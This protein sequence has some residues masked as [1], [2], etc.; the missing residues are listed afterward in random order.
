MK[1]GNSHDNILP[2]Q[3]RAFEKLS[4]MASV[5]FTVDRTQFPLNI[6]PNVCIVGPSGVGK[7]HL[8]RAVGKEIGIPTFY[9]NISTWQLLGS[10]LRGAV[11]TWPTVFDFL[12]SCS[13][14]RGAIIIVDE[15]DKVGGNTSW[16]TYLRS[17]LFDLLDWRIPRNLKDSDD[18]MISSNRIFLA[19]KTLREKT[20]IVG[21][22]AF[23]GFWENDSKSGIGFLQPQFTENRP[24]TRDLSKTLPTEL[25]NRFGSNIISLPPLARRDYLG[26]LDSFLGRMPEFCRERFEVASREGIDEAVRLNLGTRFFEETLLMTLMDELGDDSRC[27]PET[28]VPS[29]SPKS[30]SIGNS[31]SLGL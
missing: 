21:V 10:S 20:M 5:A 4:R 27:H 1:I 30:K 15:I 13:A 9:V 31:D 18:E 19:E 11:C 12:E 26:I 2:H 6:R 23:Q 25:S 28:V 17:E 3:N 7:T 14:K 29:K 24:D 22:G 8:A 16:T